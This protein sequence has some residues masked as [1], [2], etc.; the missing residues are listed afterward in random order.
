MEWKSWSTSSPNTSGLPSPAAVYVLL[1]GVSEIQGGWQN[2]FKK[3]WPSLLIVLGVLL[4][5][6]TE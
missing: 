6:Y 3:I 2:A 1:K 4:M 5:L